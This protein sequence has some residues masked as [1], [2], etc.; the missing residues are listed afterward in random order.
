MLGIP[1]KAKLALKT[2]GQKTQDVLSVNKNRK[3][4]AIAQ[5]VGNIATKNIGLEIPEL[6]IEKDTE[7]MPPLFALN[8]YKPNCLV[9]LK[10]S[11][12][13]DALT[14]RRAKH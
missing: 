3:Y 6:P 4:L 1:S 2:I 13:G 8:D 14:Q 5:K 10:G 7:F 11:T 12:I 9:T